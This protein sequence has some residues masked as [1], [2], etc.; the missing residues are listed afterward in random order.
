MS[1]S[2][3]ED[4]KAAQVWTQGPWCTTFE[5]RW[6]RKRDATGRPYRVLQVYWRRYMNSP[7]S[8]YIKDPQ[9]EWRDV[10]T[11]EEAP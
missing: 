11:V 4:T 3:S 7:A 5:V 8:P 10:P 1:D 9:D 6:A 2:S